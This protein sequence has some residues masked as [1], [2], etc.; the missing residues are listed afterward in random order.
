MPDR[1]VRVAAAA[2][3]ALLALATLAACAPEP[4]A[5][6]TTSPE[7]S[8]S[9]TPIATIT[10]GA[11]PS[12]T[13][14]AAIP[15]DCEEMLTDDVLAELAGIPLN[16]PDTGIDGGEQADGSLVCLWRDPAADTTY[17]MTTISAMSR[18][19]ALDLLNQLADEEDFEC[20]TPDGGTRCEKTWENE[21]YPVID[22]R[23]L[24]WRDGILIDTQYSNLAPPG[25][26]AAIVAGMWG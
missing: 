15:S 23:T 6:P 12:A 10:P 21:T 25:Y 19:P 8:M 16:D 3:S 5:T 2:A 11:S 14:T 24:F 17:L 26:T 18:G 1:R 13:P 22:G 9:P 4:G 7:A 20:Y